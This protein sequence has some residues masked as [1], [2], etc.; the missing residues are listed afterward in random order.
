MSFSIFLTNEVV[1]IVGF[2][3]LDAAGQTGWP[4][5]VRWTV[6]G[7]GLIAALGGAAAFRYIFDRPSQDWLCARAESGRSETPAGGVAISRG[8]SIPRG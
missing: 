8:S 6:W 7:C 5:A 4:M 1:R 2:G 3:T